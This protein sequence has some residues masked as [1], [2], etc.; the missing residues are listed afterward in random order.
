M[1]S[2]DAVMSFSGSPS[3]DLQAGSG[4]T[5]ALLALYRGNDVDHARKICNSHVLKMD[6]NRFVQPSH[7]DLYKNTHL[8]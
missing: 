7:V 2:G 5:V 6:V 3:A 4:E 1:A 8:S